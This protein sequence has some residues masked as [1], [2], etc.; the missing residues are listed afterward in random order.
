MTF[1]QEFPTW[2]APRW[3]IAQLRKAQTISL[4]SKGPADGPITALKAEQR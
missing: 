3:I 2:Q 1:G 4:P